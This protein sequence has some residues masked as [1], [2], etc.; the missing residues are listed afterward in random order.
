MITTKEK[1]II[2]KQPNA[3]EEDAP[4]IGLHMKH[5]TSKPLISTTDINATTTTTF[6]AFFESFKTFTTIEKTLRSYEHRITII[7]SHKAGYDMKNE[8][9]R[10]EC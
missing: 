6:T 4:P 1:G 5:A 9:D 3:T 10:K 2:T 7:G 8:G